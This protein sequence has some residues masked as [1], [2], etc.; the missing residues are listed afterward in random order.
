MEMI[1]KMIEDAKTNGI[2]MILGEELT[3]S[4][5][6]YTLDGVQVARPQKGKVNIVVK[7]DGRI[8]KT[9]VR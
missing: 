3:D 9:Y 5:R 4:D 8:L 1:A 6:I 7:S 2:D